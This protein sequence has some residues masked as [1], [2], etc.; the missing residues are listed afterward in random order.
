[1]KTV[2]LKHQL[3]LSM[4]GALVIPLAITTIWSTLSVRQLI[5][6]RLVETELPATLREVRNSIELALQQPVVISRGIAQNAFIIDWL[7]GGEP[8]AGLDHVVRYLET[9]RA[10]NDGIAAYVVSGISGNYYNTQG[11]FKTLSPDS[12]KD[13]W[14]YGFLDSGKDYELSLDID[15]ATGRPTVFINYAIR[16]DGAVRAVGGIGRSL[17]D[18]S[19]LIDAYRVGESGRVYLVDASGV[20]KLHPDKTL[21]GSQLTGIH[22][23]VEDVASF[24]DPD[25]QQFLHGERDGAPTISASIPVPL[26]GWFLVAELPA[27]ELYRGLQRTTRT[28]VG[29]AVLVAVVF[30]FFIRWLSRRIFNPI[31]SVTVA[32]LNIS[33]RGGDL[34]VRLPEH[35]KDELG[36]LARGF[37]GFVD[38]LQELCRRIVDSAENLDATSREVIRLVDA[39]SERTV[40][41]QE[42]SG[43]VAN[44]VND[45]CSRVEE[46]AGNAGGAAE[47]S[48]S[49]KA[50]C[51]AGQ[52][53]VA[54]SV[55]DIQSLDGAM[56]TA[57]TS[58]DSLAA[59]IGSITSLLEVIKGISEQ[60]NL[61]A[62]N[63]AI[64]AARAGEQGRGFAV[65][66]DEVRTLAQR[67]AQSTEEI[68]AMIVRLEESARVAVDAIREGSVKTESSV[69]SVRAAGDSLQSIAEKVVNISGM[70]R[71]IAGATEEQNTAAADINANL[72][73]IADIARLTADDVSRC[74]ELCERLEALSMELR[75][76]MESFNL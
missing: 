42:R 67:T 73:E 60:T 17:D 21:V 75:G 47:A 11:L 74:A 33:D 36:D 62:L 4:I 66:A 53:V 38:K 27:D 45:M 68:N 7:A 23:G 22:A 34:T 65:V 72:K 49:A 19:R 63:A 76:Q 8:E 24:L 70:N 41:Q 44:A 32:L 52:Q 2:R 61:L 20:V 12:G 37:N 10:A 35:R 58:V 26:I 13:G 55:A 54:S 16:V 5:E 50:E 39:T 71:Q 9:L 56:E 57:V 48:A 51:D 59:D 46:I 15:E 43:T 3:M 6:S 69:A 31:D 25:G 1:M 30:V 28:T 14:F 18:M 64:E 40:T 29:I